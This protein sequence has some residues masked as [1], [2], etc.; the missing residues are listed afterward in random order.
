MASTITASFG[1]EELSKVEVAR[2]QEICIPGHERIGAPRVGYDSAANQW[3]LEAPKAKT[4]EEVA[5]V[6]KEFEGYYVVR[7]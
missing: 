3:I 5:A 4:P 1:D 6:L 7:L 2:F